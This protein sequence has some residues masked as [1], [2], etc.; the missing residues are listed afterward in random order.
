MCVCVANRNQNTYHCCSSMVFFNPRG[1]CQNHILQTAFAHLQS[2]IAQ[3]VHHS[4]E[5]VSEVQ[6]GGG[7]P[8]PG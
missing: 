5:V 6:P 8:F 2:A 3:L 4:E 1:H 7:N